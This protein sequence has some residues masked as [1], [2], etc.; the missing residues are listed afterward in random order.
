[1]VYK[2]EVMSFGITASY[3]GIAANSFKERYANH[4]LSFSNLKYEYNTSLSKHIFGLKKINKPF[5]ISLLIVSKVKPCNPATKTCY[6][7]SMDKTCILLSENVN[8]LNKRRNSY[9]EN[10]TRPGEK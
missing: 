2:A 10:V 8:L 1:M 7:C 3:K 6:L 5:T 9:L 4:K